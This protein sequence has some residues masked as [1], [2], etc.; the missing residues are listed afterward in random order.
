MKN[1]CHVSTKA[2]WGHE[3]KRLAIQKRNHFASLF[4]LAYGVTDAMVTQKV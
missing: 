4:C 3:I 2:T 1:F